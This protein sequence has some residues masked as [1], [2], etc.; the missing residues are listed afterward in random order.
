MGRYD[1]SPQR[2]HRA[3]THLREANRIP[4]LPPWYG[5]VGTYPPSERLVRPALQRGK[6]RPGRASRMFKPIE[7]KYPEDKLRDD[8]FNDHPWELARPR[9][10]LESDGKDYQRQNWEGIDHTD[11]PLNGERCVGPTQLT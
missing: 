5:A 9:T 8:F 4:V 1:F 11:R 3:V 2:V 10:V 7:I 6:G